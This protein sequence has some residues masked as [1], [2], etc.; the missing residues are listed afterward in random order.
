MGIRPI[1]DIGHNIVNPTIVLCHRYFSSATPLKSKGIIYPVDEFE[2]TPDMHQTNELSFKIYKN[3]CAVWDDVTD[4]SVI[5]IPE[6]NEYFQ[7]SVDKDESS[8]TVKS[9]TGQNLGVAELSQTML[10]DIE[11]NTEDDIARDDYVIAKIYDPKDVGNSSLGRI[12]SKAP[13][14][15]IK[16]VDSTISSLVRSFSIDDKSIYDFLS[17]DL[18]DELNCLVIIGSDRTVSL[19]D[20][21]DYCPVCKQRFE[22]AEICPTCKKVTPIQRGYGFE[23]NIYIS[24]DNLASDISLNSNEDELKNTFR[25]QGGD[26]NITAAV[27]AINP[28]GT[29]YINRFPEFMFSDMSDELRQK[30][31]SYQKL[32]NSKLAT[33]RAN[34]EAIY[35]DIDQILYYTSE[36]MP[37]PGD[38]TAEKE[39]EKLSTTNLQNTIGTVALQSAHI[40]GI[41]TVNNAIKTLVQILMAQNYKADIV[42]G[43][44]SYDKNTNTWT[45]RF[46]VYNTKNRE[47]QASQTSPVTITTEENQIKYVYQKFDCT[48]AKQGI[49]NYDEHDSDKYDSS[50]WKEYCLNRL[51]SFSDAYQSCLDILI[52]MKANLKENE[53]NAIYKDY[54]QR[55]KD[56]DKEIKIRQATI[57]NFEKDKANREKI[58]N[59]IQDQL[60]LEKYLGKELYHE[61]CTYRREDTYQNDNYISDGLNNKEVL[62]KAEEL[63]STANKELYKASELQYELSAT[64][65]NL[66]AMKE[67]QSLQDNFIPGAWIHLEIDGELYKLRLLDYTI[68]SSSISELPC[69]FSTVT[70]IQDGLT[71]I[72][73]VLSNAKSMATSYECVKRQAKKGEDTNKS[74]NS[75]VDNGLNATAVSLKNTDDQTVV[76]DEH[77]ILCRSYDDITESYD[78]EQLKIINNTI[79]VTNDNWETIKTALGKIK[80]TDPSTG[81][82]KDAYG[83]IAETIVG[84]LILGEALEI[85]NSG[86]SM[87]FNQ[88]GLTITNGSTKFSVN[89]NS[90]NILAITKDGEAIMKVSK[91]GNAFFSGTVNA[92]KGTI[93]SWKISNTRLASS[94]SIFIGSNEAGLMFINEEDK[95][96]IVVQNE[97]GSKPFMI[98]RDGSM[99]SEKGNV[100]GWDIKN[101]AIYNDVTVGNDV[102]RVYF[103][104]PL[105]TGEKSWI[106]SCQKS[107]DGGKSFTGNFILFS[108]GSAS[109]GNGKTV[110]NSDGSAS[111]ANKQLTVPVSGNVKTNNIQSSGNIYCDTSYVCQDKYG[112]TTKVLTGTGTAL[113]FTGGILTSIG[114]E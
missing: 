41:S 60:N 38:T 111:F 108:D 90:D 82:V 65:G 16:Q 33:Y 86:G 104:P 101:N 36:M 12:L 8:S 7:I 18:A 4:L 17:G 85:A 98:G 113:H 9:I 28:N 5:Y 63:L 13:H 91:T 107:T 47:D 15:S 83:L 22:N 51:K 81:T 61:Y 25:V 79:A 55:K 23:T 6:Y 49:D 67:F 100:G 70:K 35:E 48:L 45:G 3:S 110:I 19:Y 57:D 66:F 56:V 53:F 84:K 21:E 2:I 46:Y 10:Y 96:Y 1:F 109:F 29:S 99:I 87:T 37:K 75:W 54:L 69:N 73:S 62:D 64:I 112:I 43:S 94:D 24:K 26:D 14:Y 78:D 102:Y 68:K 34:M 103:Q 72:K 32:Y 39:L 93:G 59:S 95:P 71:D 42:D 88:N 76:F 31:N 106:L 11:I 52:E 105:S 27:R 58:T 89:P 44:A 114:K 97:D 40:S 92:S 30:L 50:K 20:L 77:G 80:Y 74:V